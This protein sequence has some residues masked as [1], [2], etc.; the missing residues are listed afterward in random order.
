MHIKR[1]YMKEW[2]TAINQ[3]RKIYNGRTLAELPGCKIPAAFWP[4]FVGNKTNLRKPKNKDKGL[5]RSKSNFGYLE[6]N[7]LKEAPKYSTTFVKKTRRSLISK[8]LFFLSPRKSQVRGS[9]M[10]VSTQS[11]KKL[12]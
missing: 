5:I 2:T 10:C 3:G 4:R 9:N 1:D 8:W 11:V 7:T 12:W 6:I